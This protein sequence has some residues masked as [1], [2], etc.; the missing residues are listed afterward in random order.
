[1]ALAA[2]VVVPA[3]A[4]ASCNKKSEDAK[5]AAGSGSAAAPAAAAQAKT[6]IK[7]GMVASF[8]G[9]FADV[10]KQL[11]GGVKTY[12]K[13]HGDTV[14]GKKIELLTRD[15][16]GP[17]PEVAKRLA[18]E[19]VVQDKVDFLTG[20]GLTPEA[21]AAAQVATE[22]KTPMVIM[23]AATSIITTKSPYIVRFSLTLPQ[24][25]APLGDWAAKNGIKKVV[26]MVADYGPGHD[27]EAA[28]TKAFTAGGGQVIDAIRTPVQNPDFSSFIQR[29]KDKQPDAVFVFVP[30]GQQSIAAMKAYDERGLGKAG[31]KLI[32]TG[33]VLDDHGLA[34]I[35]DPALGAISSY[36]YSVA[37]DS[38]ENKA[39][40]EAYRDANG[41]EAGLPNF[42]S[43]AAY[44]S[45]AAIYDVIT[46]LDGKIDADKAM[47]ILKH[48]AFT[49]PRGPIAIDPE[50]RDIV[51]TVYLRRV[52][53]VNG[54]LRSVELQPLVEHMKDPGKEP[55]K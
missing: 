5:P 23:N 3:L 22:G 30:A 48:E 25:C 32:A 36:H 18:Q 12:M 34:T 10:G 14:A 46:K 37:H 21:L 2:L 8:S 27:A 45:M 53:R 24:V 4:A 41:A 38:P 26:T 9:P 1:V 28:F 11:L 13:Q 6:T 33:D 52:D 49:S 29:V 40:L 51:Q 17:V 39:F 44:D 31:I 16:T 54:E 20:F 19:L 55:G 35:G 42:M 7:I 47:D 43:V 50:T 15:T